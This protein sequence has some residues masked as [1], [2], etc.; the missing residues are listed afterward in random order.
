M[1]RIEVSD[2]EILGDFPFRRGRHDRLADRRN[3][4][5]FLARAWADP[6]SRVLVMR[7]MYVASE[8]ANGVARQNPSACGGERRDAPQKLRFLPTADAPPGDRMLLGGINDVVYFLV[9][10]GD[11]AIGGW[12]PGGAGQAGSTAAAKNQDHPQTS[13]G[14]LSA[15]PTSRLHSD[16]SLTADRFSSLRRLATGLSPE[17]ASLAVHAV[18]L[19]GWHLRHPRCSACGASTE[20]TEAG[21][22]RRCPACDALHFPRTDPAVIML[23]VDDADRCL[24]AHNAARPDGFFSTLAGFVE[25]GESPE[26]AVV[27]EVAEETA[28]EVAEVQY[29]GSQPWPF[30]SQLMLGYLARGRTTDVAVDGDEIAEARWFTREQLKKAVQSGEVVLPT[31]ISIS[32]ALVEHWYGGPLPERDGPATSS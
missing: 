2:I 8:P 21:A 28:V 27:R 16:D 32:H 23:V 29:V 13:T 6:A 14:G 4:A 20:V 24:L 12:S 11:A 9:L 30:P 31:P 18:A 25:P 3:D 1:A 5:D 15:P 26:D 17:E 7:D 10:E 22:S 19:A